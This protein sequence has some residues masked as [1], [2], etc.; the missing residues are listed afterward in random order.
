M[1]RAQ[2]QIRQ[3]GGQTN[4]KCKTNS[5]CFR[6]STLEGDQVNKFPLGRTVYTW[7]N[8]FASIRSRWKSFKALLRLDSACPCSSRGCHYYSS[9]SKGIRVTF[10]SDAAL[11]EGTQCI[12]TP[13]IWCSQ[14]SFNKTCDASK[15]TQEFE[16]RFAR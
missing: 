2:T 15:T 4:K 14:I 10:G 11:L 5:L 16:E 3:E 12:I 7:R 1:K 6:L 8:T 9:Q 13:G